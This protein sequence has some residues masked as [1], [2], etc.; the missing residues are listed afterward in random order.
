MTRFRPTPPDIE[1]DQAA[2]SVLLRGAAWSPAA[3]RIREA[4]RA[5]LEARTPKRRRTPD[6]TRREVEVALA[7]AARHRGQRE[8]ELVGRRKR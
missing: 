6:L 5:R 2:V 1:Q 4:K 8:R 7:H 3:D